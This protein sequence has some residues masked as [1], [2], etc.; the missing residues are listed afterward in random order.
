MVRGLCKTWI[1]RFQA[2][3]VSPKAPLAVLG[4]FLDMRSSKY[5]LVLLKGEVERCIERI[6]MGH[7]FIG[8]K[9]VVGHVKV[10]SVEPKTKSHGKA[11][12]ILFV[13]VCEIILGSCDFEPNA[14]SHA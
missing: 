3:A 13:G 14:L 7:A 8:P 1:P 2:G 4:E 9:F 11:L 12:S 5:M 10:L 6:E